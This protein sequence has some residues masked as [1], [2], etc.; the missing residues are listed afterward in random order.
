MSPNRP[1]SVLPSQVYCG[2]LIS[3]LFP[4]CPHF[5]FVLSVLFV[6]FSPSLLLYY[7]YVCDRIEHITFPF[8]VFFNELNYPFSV[9][10]LYL[11]WFYTQ[12]I[13]FYT[14]PVFDYGLPCQSPKTRRF[15]YDMD[16]PRHLSVL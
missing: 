10:S 3:P 5:R 8:N 6:R 13:Y 16:H 9:I 15:V 7:L 12:R 1:I 4:V 2:L 14:Y 11:I